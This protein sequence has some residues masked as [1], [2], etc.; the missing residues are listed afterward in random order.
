[1]RTG[2]PTTIENPASNQPPQI[3]TP[4]RKASGLGGPGFTP[5]A[6]PHEG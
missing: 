1:M 3:V 2:V 4:T 6:L 5:R